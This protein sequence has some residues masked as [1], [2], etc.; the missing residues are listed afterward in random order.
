MFRPR[1]GKHLT[2][3]EAATRW[4]SDAEKRTSG[5]HYA[6]EVLATTVQEAVA[7]RPRRHAHLNNKVITTD[8]VNAVLP[9]YSADTPKS[10]LHKVRTAS[11]VASESSPCSPLVASMRDDHAAFLSLNDA[12]ARAHASSVAEALWLRG[13]LTPTEFQAI[14]RLKSPDDF[15]G[16][17]RAYAVLAETGNVSVFLRC[18]RSLCLRQVVNM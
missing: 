7:I 9:R 10:T 17:F 5:F 12:L 18:L 14:Q 1:S 11:T 8:N 6:P 3:R 13:L 2:L 15:S 16:F 4:R